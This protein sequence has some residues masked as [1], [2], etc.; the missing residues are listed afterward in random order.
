[1]AVPKAKHVP[2]RTCIGCRTTSSKREFVRIV[3]TP[4]GSIEVDATGKR[5]GRGAYVCARPECWAEAIKK[6]RLANA[7]R[8]TITQSDREA[9][10][11]YGEQLAPAAA[12]IGSKE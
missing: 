7:L 8:A 1:M 11:S 5:D 6:D 12:G 10:A 4:E 3:R 2:Q 9:L